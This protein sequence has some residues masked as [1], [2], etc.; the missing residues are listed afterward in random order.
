MNPA[1]YRGA[2][3]AVILYD[4]TSRGEPIGRTLLLAAWH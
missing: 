3:G 1:Y 4:V 2:S